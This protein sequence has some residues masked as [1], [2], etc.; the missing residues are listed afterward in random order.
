MGY[1]GSSIY[2][3]NDFFDAFLHRRNRPES[4]NNAMEKPAFLSMI[5]EV[6]DQR[7]LDLGCGDGSFGLDLCRAGCRLYEGVEGSTNMLTSAQENLR[8]VQ[9][10]LHHGMVE[11]FKMGRDVYDLI[12]SRM[13]L[14]YIEELPAVFQSVYQGLKPGGRFVF[15]VQHPLLTSTPAPSNQRGGRSDWVV[16]NY[17]HTGERKEH[18]IDHEV[19][20]Y[21]RPVED[22][23]QQLL[24]A[25]FR[26]TGVKEG[27]PEPDAFLEKKEYERRMRIP[28]FLI[29]GG[30][31]K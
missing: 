18:W 17:F 30:E 26:I 28:L 14:H 21:H 10:R 11:D 31:K 5:G 9:A 15:S 16:D 19:I 24:Q 3:E 7:V 23:V 27:C 22:Y 2:D 1:K 4:P 12:T 20:K 13:V 8:T 25:G 29:L 6:H